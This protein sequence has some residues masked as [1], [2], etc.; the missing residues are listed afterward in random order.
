VP[1]FRNLY[2]LCEHN[3]VRFYRN[4]EEIASKSKEQREQ[5]LRTT[6]ACK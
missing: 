1:A 2:E 4:V 5:I 3:F 6:Q